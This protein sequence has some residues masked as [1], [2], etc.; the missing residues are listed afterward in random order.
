[1]TILRAANLYG[2]VRAP[3]GETEPELVLLA[4]AEARAVQE[5]RRQG[6]HDAPLALMVYDGTKARLTQQR[7][8]ELRRVYLRDATEPGHHPGA[9]DGTCS[10]P[11][12]RSLS[13]GL[14]SSGPPTPTFPQYRRHEAPY[15]KEVPLL[16]VCLSGTK[17]DRCLS[18]TRTWPP[19]HHSAAWRPAH[20]F[21][22]RLTL[23]T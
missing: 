11:S 3:H 1:M 23:T 18:P 4:Q 19:L 5:L 16:Q 12:P 20:A 17:W 21:P 13:P 10:T 7:L 22:V 2:N 6:P 9:I 15:S 8:E 14:R